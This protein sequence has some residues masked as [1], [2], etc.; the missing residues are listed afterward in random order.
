ML[1]VVAAGGTHDVY[2]GEGAGIRAGLAGIFAAPYRICL[3]LAHRIWITA[4]LYSTEELA[5][6]S[7]D[8]EMDNKMIGTGKETNQVLNKSLE[9]V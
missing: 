5:R 8:S 2:E 9:Y 6:A 7:S 4:L 3:A 1:A